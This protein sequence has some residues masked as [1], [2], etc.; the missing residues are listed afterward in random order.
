MA[1]AKSVSAAVLLPL[2]AWERAPGGVSAPGGGAGLGARGRVAQGLAGVPV[3]V[4]FGGPVG[5]PTGVVGL[6]ANR[7]VEI[8]EGADPVAHFEVRIGAEPVHV[9]YVGPQPDGAGETLDGFMEI[10]G[11]ERLVAASEQV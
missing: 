7:L 1:A 10:A 5:V 11:V 2:S 3:E 9:G 8:V 6:E 4:K